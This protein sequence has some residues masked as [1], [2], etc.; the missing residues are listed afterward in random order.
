MVRRLAAVLFFSALGVYAQVT[1]TAPLSGT[2]SDP[3]G[4]VIPGAAITVTHTETGTVYQAVTGTNGTFSVPS[5]GTGTYTVRASAKGDRK[6]TRL[7]S[8]H[9]SISY[10]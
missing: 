7:N 8:S 1:A 3:S 6:S 10:A 9:M 5:L 4:S 2:V